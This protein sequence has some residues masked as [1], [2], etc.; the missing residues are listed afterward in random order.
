MTDKAVWKTVLQGICVFAE[1]I[2]QQDLTG[3]ALV[4]GFDVLLFKGF[5]HSCNMSD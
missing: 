4:E 2:C 5:P 1:S 3:M